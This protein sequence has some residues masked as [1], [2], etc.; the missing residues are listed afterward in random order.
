MRTHGLP[1]RSPRSTRSAPHSRRDRRQCRVR[2]LERRRARCWPPTRPGRRSATSPRL[3]FPGGAIDMIDAWFADI[4][5]AMVGARCRPKRL[6]AM[7]IRANGS[8]R[9]SRRGSRSL[10]PNREALRRALAILAMP[11]NL[12]ARGAKLGWRA[13][14]LMWRARRRHRDRLQ[15]LYQARR[16]WPAS[17]PRRS[18][19]SSTTRARAMADTR[20]FLARRID[21]HHALRK[22]QGAACSTRASIGRACRASSAGCAIRWC[23]RIRERLQL[24]RIVAVIVPR[25]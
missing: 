17:M 10:A 11:Q 21:G 18:R 2:R 20:A 22:G 4:D 15:S 24:T 19:C 8:P 13:A 12:R 23:E 7:K 9:W 3:A 16:S 5:A 25:Y 1:R 14:D 6:A